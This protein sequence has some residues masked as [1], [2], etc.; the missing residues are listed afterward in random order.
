MIVGVEFV[1][2]NEGIGWLIWRS[3][4]I[5]AIDR[6]IAGLIAVALVGWLMTV[7]LDELEYLLVPWQTTRMHIKEGTMR[8]HIRTWWNALRP[9]SYTAAIIP[10][11]L[12]GQHCR[13]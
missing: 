6:M 8:Q 13:L 11:L 7:L 2:A 10:V 12:G 3:Y 5:Y 9:W 1:G 4:E